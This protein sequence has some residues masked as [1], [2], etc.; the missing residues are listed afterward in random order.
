MATTGTHVKVSSVEAILEALGRHP[1]ATT[2]ELAEAADIGRSTAGKTL[3]T[4]EAQSRITRRRGTPQRG[5]PAPD[6]WTL[7][8]DPLAS[9]AGRTEAGPPPPSEVSVDE[10]ATASET[11]AKADPD[12][13]AGEATGGPRLRPGAL[14]SLVHR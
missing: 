3:A 5:K 7:V 6:R 1:H 9:H 14:R 2:T 13:P 4:L 11:P 8:S 12:Q 10:T